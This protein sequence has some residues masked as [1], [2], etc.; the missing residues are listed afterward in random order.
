MTGLKKDFEEV[1]IEALVD[2]LTEIPNRKAFSD[3]LATFSTEAHTEKKDLSFLIIDIDRFKT[4]NDEYGHLMGDAVLKFVA[5]KMKEM[6]KGKD[7]VARFGGE[8][9]AIILPETS[10]SGALS[11]A[12]HI[13]KF[14]ELSPL[15]A[16]TAL[17]K[18]GSV[19]VSTGVALYRFG[20]PLDVFINRSDRAL[21]HAKNTGR[22]RVASE[23]DLKE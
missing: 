17:K 7:F 23:Q 3:A 11:V 14:F 21:Y 16:A 10:L 13:R 8:E 19:T 20:E 1:K 2:F 22:N 15:K 12:E 9:F 5:K 18:L 4:F 6:I